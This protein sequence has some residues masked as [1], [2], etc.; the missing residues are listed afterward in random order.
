MKPS[1]VSASLRRIATAIDKSK[2][3]KRELVARDLKR[4]IAMLVDSEAP[5]GMKKFRINYPFKGQIQYDVFVHMNPENPEAEAIEAIR[6][7]KILQQAD[8]GS[9]ETDQGGLLVVEENDGDWMTDDLSR[10]D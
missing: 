10:Y 4:A 5:E 6:Q 7:G 9:F 8:N 3:P 1:Q 2:N